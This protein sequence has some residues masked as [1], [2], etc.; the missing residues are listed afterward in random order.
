[1][2]K[3]GTINEHRGSSR[4]GG[5][6]VRRRTTAKNAIASRPPSWNKSPKLLSAAI[7]NSDR[8]LSEGGLPSVVSEVKE[9][10]NPDHIAAL[11][12]RGIVRSVKFVEDH[13]VR[14]FDR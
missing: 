6:P 12:A 9:K 14:I 1:M 5:S 10:D 3:K 11:Q 13:H 2:L 4:V 8:P 7:Q